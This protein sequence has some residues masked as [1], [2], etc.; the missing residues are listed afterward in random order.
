MDGYPQFDSF[1]IKSASWPNFA[2]YL[3]PTYPCLHI[4]WHLHYHLPVKCKCMWWLFVFLSIFYS[5]MFKIISFENCLVSDCTRNPRMWSVGAP[6]TFSSLDNI[7]LSCQFKVQ[8]LSIWTI[9]CT[10]YHVG[11][12]LH[13]EFELQYSREH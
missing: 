5:F 10:F 6:L 4:G 12:V 2:H 3:P 9:H 11:Q 1:M 8:T 13:L 7:D